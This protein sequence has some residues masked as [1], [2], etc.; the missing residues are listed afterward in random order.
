MIAALLG[1]LHP[2]VVAYHLFLRVY[3]QV[4]TRLD[5]ELDA[6]YGWR[7]APCLVNFHVQLVVRNWLTTQL[8]F[9]ETGFFPAPDFCMGLNVL[10]SQKK[11]SWIPT[12]TSV[13]VLL[14]L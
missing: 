8:D 2:T 10:Q 1:N 5:G 4:F 7:L 13:P 11:I 3:E 12:V 14:A 6:A 9:R